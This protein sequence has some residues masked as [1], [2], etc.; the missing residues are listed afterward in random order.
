MTIENPEN[1]LRFWK[2]IIYWLRK[3]IYLITIFFKKRSEKNEE[4][5]KE[6]FELIMTEKDC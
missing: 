6:N 5:K 4:A 1:F 2:I 3:K